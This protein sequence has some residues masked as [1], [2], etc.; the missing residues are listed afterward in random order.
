MQ[1][2]KLNSVAESDTWKFSIEEGLAL[3]GSH[4]L[5]DNQ[6]CT[7]DGTPK[8]PAANTIYSNRKC[9]GGTQRMFKWDNKYFKVCMHAVTTS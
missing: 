7:T 1:L 3:M 5:I 6:G 4:T 9:G 8:T 2:N